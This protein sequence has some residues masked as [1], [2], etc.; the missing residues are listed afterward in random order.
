[1]FE[2][3][4][5]PFRLPPWLVPGLL[6]AFAVPMVIAQVNP[7]APAPAAQP[8]APAEAAPGQQGETVTV[9]TQERTLLE[10]YRAGGFFMHPIALCSF[11]GL[12]L[13]IERALSLRR[14]LV[15]PRSFLD[16]LRV[17]M[18]DLHADRHAGLAY[19]QANDSPIARI[20][21]AG[22]KKG[23]RGPEAVEK[24]IED[25]G[26][27]ETL[28]LRRNMRFLYS[29]ASVSTLLGL[30]GTIQGMIGAFQAAEA[31]GTGKFGPLAAGIYTALITT[32]AGLAVAIPITVFYFYFAGR[33]DRLVAEMNDVA[34]D[35]ADDYTTLPGQPA[36][37][38]GGYRGASP[39]AASEA[40]TAS[41]LGAGYAPA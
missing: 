34:N 17:S 38:G 32:F 33:I 23:P 6:F 15:V 26:A 4:K 19:C 22:I 1:M 24:A 21:A 39:A 40:P 8:A 35:F 37:A 36:V 9:K 29:L 31:V 7:P 41:S 27:I 13:V 18:R 10:W 20:M 25:A 2:P 16:G 28:K 12:A 11:I 3:K 5:R 14:G 30:L